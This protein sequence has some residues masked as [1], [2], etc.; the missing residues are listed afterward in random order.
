MKR[1]SRTSILRMVPHLSQL[2]WP[3][4]RRVGDEPAGRVDLAET[5][6]AVAA[7]VAVRD[8]AVVEGRAA[9]SS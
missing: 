4:E 6:I 5:T 7:V 1:T 8:R 3:L 9:T 2:A